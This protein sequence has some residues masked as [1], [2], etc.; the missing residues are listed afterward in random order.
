MPHPVVESGGTETGKGGSLQKSTVH[1]K[2]T[3]MLSR[4][5]LATRKNG[6]V[7]GER[8]VGRR[9]DGGEVV[10]RTDNRFFEEHHSY[11][12]NLLNEE[13]TESLH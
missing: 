7:G 3:A 13:T 12:I 9:G 6:S 4:S 5:P 2:E 11:P 10:V 8:R 1:G